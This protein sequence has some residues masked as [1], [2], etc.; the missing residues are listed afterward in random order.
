MITPRGETPFGTQ[1]VLRRPSQITFNRA[2]APEVTNE[3]GA[4]HAGLL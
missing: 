4:S 2:K 3:S 1:I